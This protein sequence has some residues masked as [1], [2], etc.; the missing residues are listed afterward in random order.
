M[1]NVADIDSVAIWYDGSQTDGFTRASNSDVS[2]VANKGNMG[3]ANFT[4]SSAASQP[5]FVP[6]RLNGISALQFYDDSTAKYMTV[7]DSAAL[8][9]SSTG[10]RWYAVFERATLTAVQCIMGKFNATGNI[11]EFACRLSVAD[12]ATVVHMYSSNGTAESSFQTVT[13]CAVGSV[14]IAN[15]SW[16]PT[17]DVIRVRNGAASPISV[18]SVTAINNSTS[19]FSIG[20][21]A[22][23]ANPFAG[24]IYEAI[25]RPVFGTNVEH[26]A[27]T[28]YLQ[29]KYRIIT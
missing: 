10:Y 7:A 28:R 21:T 16:D 11:R 6:S 3:A 2:V 29:N 19:P 24:Y 8:D 14:I 26:D 25:F 9:Y 1:F 27:I 17:L 18:G 12:P 4:Q 15:G 20:A 5:L 13:T 22:S 23:G